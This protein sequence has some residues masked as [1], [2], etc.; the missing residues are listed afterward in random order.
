MLS[1]LRIAVLTAVLGCFLAPAAPAVAAQLNSI[2]VTESASVPVVQPSWP[3]PRDPNQVLYLQR[4]SN[5]NTI[6]FTAV[7]D[8][9]GNLRAKRPAQVYWRRYNTTGERK[10]LK[11]FERALAF[12][13]NF[14]P[15]STPGAYDV[16]L[17][18]L[19]QLPMLLRQTA[20]GKAELFARIGGRTVR[21]VYA[22]VSL[23]E[24]GWIP[25]VTHLT[26][27]GVDPATGRA[28]TEVFRVQG[29]NVKY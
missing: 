27:H 16:H 8:A 17:K 20:P 11:P 4:S 9:N 12:G 18:P 29:G 13:M 2:R 28:V 26:L 23:D 19:P 21:A 10:A 3:I 15:A 25:R 14:K 6:V 7:F 5:S 24:S 1:L 22:Y